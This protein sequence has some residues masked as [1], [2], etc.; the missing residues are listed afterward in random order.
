MFVLVEGHTIG[1]YWIHSFSKRVPQRK[2]TLFNLLP[3]KSD[4][5]KFETRCT[6]LTITKNKQTDNKVQTNN[7]KQTN[8][9]H[10]Q[11]INNTNKSGSLNCNSHSLTLLWL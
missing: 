9:Q 10:R 4:S 8:S 2:S 5:Y 6:D 11:Q 1:Q 3:E 7:N